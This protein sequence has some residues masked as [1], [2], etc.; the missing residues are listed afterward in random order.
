MDDYTTTGGVSRVVMVKE[1]V[2]NNH[3]NNYQ[4][5][6]KQTEDSLLLAEASV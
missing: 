3:T 5:S 1:A 6:S 4:R 2:V